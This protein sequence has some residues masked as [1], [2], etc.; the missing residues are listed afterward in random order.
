[1]WYGL[2]F[3]LI[4][5][6]IIY[7]MVEAGLVFSLLIIALTTTVLVFYFKLKNR[8]AE[9]NASEG[10]KARFKV[11]ERVIVV[12][13]IIMIMVGLIMWLVGISNGTPTISSSGNACGWCGGNGKFW[14]SECWACDGFGVEFSEGTS[15]SSSTS[16]GLL[17]AVSSALVVFVSFLNKKGFFD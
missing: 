9:E 13:C 17:M 3:L 2:L 16:K 10:V 5:G 11:Y 12:V 7:Q 1:M 8:A 14:G 6:L 15:Y 4:I